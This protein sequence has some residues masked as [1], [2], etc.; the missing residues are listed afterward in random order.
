MD[1]KREIVLLGVLI[2]SLFVINYNFVD[3]AIVEF[4]EDSET[5]DV[6]RVIDGDTIVISND[7]HVRLLGINTPEK[8]EKYYNEAKNFLTGLVLN[9]TIKTES[10]KEK[11]DKYRREL[12]FIFLDGKSVN[13]E[14]VRNGFANVYILD[15]KKYEKELRD[16][17]NECVEKGG[18]L[19]EKSNDK[20]SDCI[21]LTDWD[22]EEQNF[23]LDNRCEF[24]CDLTEWEVKDEGRK[25]F[26]FGKFILKKDEEIKIIVGNGEDNENILYWGNEDYVWTETGDTLFLR[27][28]EGK[29]VLWENY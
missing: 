14:I 29:L 23:I 4:L 20:C 12:A 17:W 26:I 8:G 28:S 3:N 27:D 21:K 25:K 2:L 19:C 5:R 22:L 6:E 15:D 7:T 16:A 9:K 18:N 24:D 10:G 11:Y 13:L 1:R